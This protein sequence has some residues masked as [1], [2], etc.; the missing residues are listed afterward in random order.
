MK[1]IQFTPHPLH[2]S[3]RSQFRQV[4]KNLAA[5]ALYNLEMASRNKETWTRLAEFFHEVVDEAEESAFHDDSCT[6]WG[7]RARLL[8]GETNLQ[9]IDQEFAFFL[10]TFSNASLAAAVSSEADDQQEALAQIDALLDYLI[11]ETADALVIHTALRLQSNLA[12]AA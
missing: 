10:Q 7:I 11:T 9:K 8:L 1:T 5:L 12:M 6:S 3:N 4:A 2:Y